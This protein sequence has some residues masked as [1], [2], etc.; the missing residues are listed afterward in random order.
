[1]FHT[2]FAQDA[3]NRLYMS[4]QLSFTAHIMI[5]KVIKS[6]IYWKHKTIF[7]S[8]YPFQETVP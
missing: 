4:L 3:E 1:M 8:P 2:Y 5:S 6:V 7:F